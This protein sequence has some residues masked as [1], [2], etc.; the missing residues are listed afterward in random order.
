MS[1]RRGQPSADQKSFS[2]GRERAE[3]KKKWTNS[4]LLG[5]RESQGSV[6]LCPEGYP[7][8]W[9]SLE[10]YRSWFLLCKALL[11]QGWPL[12]QFLVGSAGRNTWSNLHKRVFLILYPQCPS[13]QVP[14]LD[15]R[16]GPFYWTS[17][18]KKKRNK[19]LFKSFKG[20][21]ATI[22]VNHIHIF[23]QTP[24]FHFNIEQAMILYI[25]II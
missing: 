21:H 14:T 18:E 7:S 6:A 11:S 12:R 22:W 4:W 9:G 5:I 19:V 23:P 20:L 2:K 16:Q 1:T 3:W 24:S 17:K 8:R 25:N 15:S 10:G 13:K